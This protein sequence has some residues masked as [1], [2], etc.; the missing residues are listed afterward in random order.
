V[1]EPLFTVDEVATRLR[2]NKVTVLRWIRSKKLPAINLGG[3]SGYRIRGADVEALLWSSYGGMKGYLD[4]AARALGE[5]AEA[6]RDYADRFD[7]EKM[8]V[9]SRELRAEAE[10]LAVEAESFRDV[11]GFYGPPRSPG[12][13]RELQPYMAAAYESGNDDFRMIAKI[14]RDAIAADVTESAAFGIRQ[15]LVRAEASNP[16]NSEHGRLV[17]LAGPLVLQPLTER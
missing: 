13:L 16:P 9:R 1:S 17:R 7:N 15:W 11:Q 2:L 4:R 8:A 12:T 3:T 6:A 10:R 5:A 14:V